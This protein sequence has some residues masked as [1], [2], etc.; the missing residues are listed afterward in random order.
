MSRDYLKE[1]RKHSKTLFEMA[2]REEPRTKEYKA[3]ICA[4]A[5]LD[6]D[7]AEIETNLSELE[8]YEE[9]ESH[10]YRNMNPECK[11]CQ[12]QEKFPHAKKTI[13]RK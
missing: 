12:F 8:A 10:D 3:L 9:H 5:K 2:L 4:C 11:F 7:I 1:L 6:N 13:S